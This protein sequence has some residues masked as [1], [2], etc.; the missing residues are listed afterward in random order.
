MKLTTH[1][2]VVPRLR[3]CVATPPIPHIGSWCG[4]SFIKHRA[5]F[6][7]TLEAQSQFLMFIYKYK[8]LPKQL[9]NWLTYS[10][11]W[12][13]LEELPILQLLKNFPA[14][15]GTHRFIT[16]FTRALHW[17]LSWARSI[18]SILD[19]MVASITQVQSPLNFLLNQVSICCCCSQI[20][21]LCHIFK[22][23]IKYVV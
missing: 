7:F 8:I 18:Q 6:T 4:A 17:S 22:T 3:M 16:V 13:L 14:F 19:W 20:S 12:A 2:H 9:F 21:E 1:L 23:H 5:N 10:W 15:Y 11:S